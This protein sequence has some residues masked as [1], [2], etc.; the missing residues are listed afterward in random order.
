M[1]DLGMI[2]YLGYAALPEAAALQSGCWRSRA[3]NSRHGVHLIV[4][5][6]A[7]GSLVVGDSHHYAATPD[8]FA[9]NAVDELILEELRAVFDGRRPRLVERWTGTYASAPDRSMLV[10]RA[11]RRRAPRHDHQRHRR[12]HLLRDRRRGDRRTLRLNSERR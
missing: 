4:V 1:S 3:S 11:G 2:R 12:Q 5:Q 10:D 9:P 7:D 8:P 6:S